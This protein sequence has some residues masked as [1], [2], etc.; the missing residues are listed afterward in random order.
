MFT[1]HLNN[2]KFFSFHGLYQEE[3]ILGGQFEV[4]VAV[5][6]KEDKRITEIQQAVDYVKVY[7][8]IKQ[9]MEIP[10]PLLETV[11]QDLAEKIYRGD[12]RITSISISIKKT[13]PP[14]AAFMGTVGV[15]YKKDF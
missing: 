11:A 6:C 9:Q 12:N 1:I 13:H 3:R 7:A 5:T 10:T 2:L 8:I 14:I 4:D 15:S